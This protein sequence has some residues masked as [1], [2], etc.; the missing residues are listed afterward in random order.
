MLQSKRI[1]LNSF[2]NENEKSQ[3]F[4]L[5]RIDFSF[6]ECP[7]GRLSRKLA[8]SRSKMTTLKVLKRSKETWKIRV[9]TQTGRYCYVFSV[10][11]SALG[12][13]PPFLI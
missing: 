7:V 12:C 4:F 2:G 6:P 9:M 8:E 13:L 3:L 1:Y 10:S 5:G 11:W